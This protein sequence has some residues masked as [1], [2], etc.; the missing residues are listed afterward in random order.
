M[1]IEAPVCKDLCTQILCQKLNARPKSI[2]GKMFVK[3]S[4]IQIMEYHAATG[5][6]G[7]TYTS[8]WK[9]GHDMFVLTFYFEIIEDLLESYKRDAN[10]FSFP[11]L[12]DAPVLKILPS[13]CASS[14]SLG[15]NNFLLFFF[16]PK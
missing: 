1:K 3:H 9:D 2:S 6:T 10:I 15:I 4:F 11:L 7:H 14:V 13:L 12:S 16:L 5:N 8:D